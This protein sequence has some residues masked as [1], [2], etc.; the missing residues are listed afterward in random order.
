MNDLGIFQ[1]KSKM[2]ELPYLLTSASPWTLGKTQLFII[3]Q[4]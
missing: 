4:P 2:Q 3:F 1:T